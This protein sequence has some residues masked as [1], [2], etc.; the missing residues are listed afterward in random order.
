MKMQD[1]INEA[2]S[3]FGLTPEQRKLANLGRT[4]MDQ[5]AVTKDD[6]LSNVMAKVGNEL[7]NFGAPFGAKNLGELVKKTSVSAEVIQ[8]LLAYADKIHSSHVALNKDNDD[9][10]LDDTDN[11][12]NDFMEPDDDE[13]AAQADRAARAKRK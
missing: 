10:G 5:A 3:P 12:D 9:S 6:D 7:T 2:D 13:M 11:D 1:I 8:K 4:L